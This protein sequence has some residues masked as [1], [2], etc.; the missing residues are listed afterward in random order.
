MSQ[1]HPRQYST[2]YL[3]KGNINQ[4]LCRKDHC[5]YHSTIGEGFGDRSTSTRDDNLCYCTL[6]SSLGGKIRWYCVFV[7]VDEYITQEGSGEPEAGGSQNEYGV[8]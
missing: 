4:T 2:P 3:G 5:T 7:I 8:Y 1:L 6:V